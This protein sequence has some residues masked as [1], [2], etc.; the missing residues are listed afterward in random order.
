MSCSSFI[1]FCL[2]AYADGDGDRRRDREEPPPARHT[3]GARAHGLG[4]DIWNLARVQGGK[5]TVSALSG[6]TFTLGVVICHASPVKDYLLEH[7]FLS[8][9]GLETMVSLAILTSA[10][11]FLRK[12]KHGIIKGNCK[13]HTSRAK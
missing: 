2:Y 10:S 9:A 13:F 12:R 8:L 5:S 1:V 4:S 11:F 6:T 3:Q 7:K